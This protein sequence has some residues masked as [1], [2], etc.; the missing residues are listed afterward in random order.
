[1]KGG[2]GF[3]VWMDRFAERAPIQVIRTESNES[4]TCPIYLSLSFSCK[5]HSNPSE[6]SGIPS[7]E[8]DTGSTVPGRGCPWRSEG[9]SV[10]NPSVIMCVNTVPSPTRGIP[11]QIRLG[12]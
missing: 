4:G 9:I 12:K 8:L 11:I 5:L 2:V 3:S 7:S 10:S 6:Q 1:M